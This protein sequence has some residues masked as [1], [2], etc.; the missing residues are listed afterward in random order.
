MLRIAGPAQSLPI[1]KPCATMKSQITEMELLFARCVL[2][3][4]Y[5]H[6]VLYWLYNMVKYSK[7]LLNATQAGDRF[8]MN[9]IKL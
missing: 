6:F 3:H 9:K 4:F 8:E 5:C 2:F 1:A 7:L